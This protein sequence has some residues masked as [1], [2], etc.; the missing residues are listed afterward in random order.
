M[1]EKEQYHRQDIQRKGKRNQRQAVQEKDL[2]H[3]LGKGIHLKEKEL[4][5]PFGKRAVT[6]DCELGLSGKRRKLHDMPAGTVFPVHRA[7]LTEGIEPLLVEIDADGLPCRKE[8]QG[9]RPLVR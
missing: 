8:K 9:A 6:F 1:E 4:A 5:G 3:D 2:L 7:Q